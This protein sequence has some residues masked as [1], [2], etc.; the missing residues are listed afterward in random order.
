MNAKT[1]SHLRLLTSVCAGAM[2]LGLAGAASAQTPIVQPGAPGEAA[3]DLSADEA[4]KIADTS[5]SADDVKFM[6]DMIPHHYQAVE[7]SALVKERTNNADILAASG[8]IDASQED[9]ISFMQTWL[10]E[11]GEEAPDPAAGGHGGHGSHGMSGAHK[12]MAGMA[13]PE[14]MKALAAAKGAEFDRMFLTLMIAHH[15]GAVKMVDHLL[16]QPGSAYDPVL[17]DFVNEVKNGQTA[18]IEKMNALLAGLST[19]PRV[20][21]K[22]GFRDAGEAIS[23]LELVA[24]LP[25]PSGF[26][27][28]EN[29]ADL[30]PVKP[31]KD[32]EGRG[33]G[34]GNEGTEWGERSPLL[35]FSNTDM[36][37]TGDVMVVG[38]YHGFNIYK[39]QADG[40]PELFSSVVCPGGQGDVSVVGDLLIMS[41]EQTRGRTDCGL[42]GVSDD[43]S[44]D[45]FR[46][47]RIFDISDLSRPVQVGQVQTCRGSHTHSVV[48]AD[49]NKIVV[50]NSGTAGVRR[51]E[52]LPGCV[53]AIPGDSRTALFS[54]DV[55]EIPVANPS[56]ARIVDSPRVFA[57]E[58]TG[59]IAGLWQGGDH[60]DDT[61]TTSQTN[62]CHDITVFP[63]KKIA[64]GA[65]SGNG[66]IFDI[67]NPLKPKR[68][69]AVT[70]KGFAYWHS[71]T[72][73][74]DGTKV[75]FTDEWGGGSRPRCRASDPK[76]WGADAFYDIVGGKLEYK[77]VY[78][79]PAPQS[80]KENCVA[81]NGSIIPV[82]GRDIF[83]QAWYQ[84][85]L[86]VIDFT[87]SSNPVEIAYF[88]RGPIDAEHLILGGYWSTYWY[89]G[90]IYGTAISRGLDVLALTPGEM[91]TENEIAAA[92]LADQGKT[93]NPQD[94]HPVSWPAEPVIARAYMDQLARSETL[95]EGQMKDLAAALDSAEAALEKGGADKAVSDKLKSLA[96]GLKA[97]GD[98]A[99]KKRIAGLSETLNGISAR[100][101]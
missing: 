78:K 99:A 6:Q 68:I 23:N 13:T 16:A 53:G 4:V 66:I 38:N 12:M 95:S 80:D 74:N 45:R 44:P 21:L 9:E 62:Q 47:I 75:L 17:F 58:K 34:Q 22:P 83:V 70:D 88:D 54:I 63:S 79:L 26:F 93:F 42:Q 97:A 86:S 96:A 85:G 81:H 39:L 48:S 30:P 2:L 72:F 100:L 56:K 27:D 50:Y 14:Q 1:A 8:R 89:Q 24:A 41:V 98:D 32:G 49:K 55:I 82:P 28:P 3:R 92:T 25:K 61:Q 67:A 69:D 76:T 101:R 94:Q 46:G 59:N 20:G 33:D 36:A 29:P 90:K 18:E 19:D 57:D 65:C 71:A 5:Y 52:E 7:M 91:M 35:S 15:E 11:R 87:D 73:N 37:F 43:V 40:M 77:G 51:E 64:A 84:G 31:A 60:G 10:R